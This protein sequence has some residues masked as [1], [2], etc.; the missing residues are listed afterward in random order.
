MAELLNYPILILLLIIQMTIGRNFHLVGGTANLVLLWI[1]CWGLHKQGKHVWYGAIFAGLIFSYSSAMPWYAVFIGFIFAAGASRFFS[2]RFWQNPLIALFLVSFI[3]SLFM[4]LIEY[5]VLRVNGV[6]L[7]WQL[8]L[9]H[10]ILPSIFLDLILALPVY[11]LVH[12]MSH[13]VYP[14]EVEE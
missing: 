3:S 1:V 2:K 7:A 9:T 11:A 6:L 8:S 12:D 13:W 4:N 10:V 14:V 5:I